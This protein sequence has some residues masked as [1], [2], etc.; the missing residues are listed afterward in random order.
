MDRVPHSFDT[1]GPCSLL[2]TF[3]AGAPLLPGEPA[4]AD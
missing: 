3:A 1:N 2:V 4:L